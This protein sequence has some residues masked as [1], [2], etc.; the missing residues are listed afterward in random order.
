MA[1][2]SQGRR[3]ACGT[4]EADETVEPDHSGL[5]EPARRAR[6]ARLGYARRAQLRRERR[7][8][9]GRIRI[10]LSAQPR[11]EIVVSSERS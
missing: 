5:V 3:P 1:T 11:G 7:G 8:L 2:A 9:S 4:S 10:E 6:R